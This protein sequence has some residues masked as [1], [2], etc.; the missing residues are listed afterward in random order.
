MAV[1]H[2]CRVVMDDRDARKLARHHLQVP[3][4]GTLGV[5]ARPVDTDRQV[6]GEADLL[7]RGMIN[8]GY[9]SPVTALRDFN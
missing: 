2:G 5:L 9:H 8:A 1:E 6:S 7:L 3:L 4:S